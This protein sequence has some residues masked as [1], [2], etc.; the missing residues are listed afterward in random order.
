[1]GNNGG[2]QCVRKALSI[3]FGCCGPEARK[4]RRLAVQSEQREQQ[5]EDVPLRQGGRATTESGKGR[6]GSAPV[7][8]HSSLQP[9]SSHSL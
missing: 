2:A 7:F 3:K 9:V 6:F 1:M 8:V 4:S 5:E